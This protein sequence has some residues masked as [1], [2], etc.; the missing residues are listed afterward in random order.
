MGPNLSLKNNW[1]ITK[2]KKILNPN[3]TDQVRLNLG[4][5]SI[6]GLLVKMNTIQITASDSIFPI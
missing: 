5:V 6:S 1:K 2:I 4:Q 3:K